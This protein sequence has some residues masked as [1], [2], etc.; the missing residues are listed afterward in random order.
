MFTQ[1]RDRAQ[2]T[3]LSE[4][5]LPRQSAFS[6]FSH[7]SNFQDHRAPPGDSGDGLMDRALALA[8]GYPGRR[9]AQRGAGPD[10]RGGGASRGGTRTGAFPRL[11]RMHRITAFDTKG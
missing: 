9:G 11:S 6:Y 4:F 1:Y 7:L 10:H 3:H 5:S 8:F 2:K